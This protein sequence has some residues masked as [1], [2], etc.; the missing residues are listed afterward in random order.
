MKYLSMTYILALELMWVN[1]ALCCF[2]SRMEGFQDTVPK[3]QNNECLP[4]LHEPERPFK[5]TS[6]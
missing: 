6:L 3:E 1:V 5:T 2:K 4:F